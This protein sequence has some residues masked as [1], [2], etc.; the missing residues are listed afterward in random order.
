MTDAERPILEIA[1]GL[2]PSAIAQV[3]GYIW[4]ACRDDDTLS[5]RYRDFAIKKRQGL[6]YGFRPTALAADP[7]GLT[8]V[9]LGAGRRELRRLDAGSGRLLSTSTH[10]AVRINS[11]LTISPDGD[12]Y[13]PVFRSPL[14]HGVIQVSPDLRLQSEILLQVDQDR[15]MKIAGEGFQHV[16]RMAISPC[17]T[18][19]W[20][21]AVKAN[22]QRGMFR[23]EQPLNFENT[24]RT[25][26]GSIDLK[27]GNEI[28]A[29]HRL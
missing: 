8:M 18:R 12:L 14:N 19:A 9:V 16:S 21:P 23:D 3:S 11:Q 7:D 26:A 1:V 2:H 17:G 13:V 28:M 22:I 4:V 5:N 10:D 27:S 24:V 20:Y 6:P 15:M 29:L 25:M